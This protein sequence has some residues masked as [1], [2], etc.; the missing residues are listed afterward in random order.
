MATNITS[1]SSDDRESRSSARTRIGFLRTRW[2]AIGAAVAVSLGAG[3]IGLVHATVDSGD[4]P[5]LVD[6]NP[7]RLTDTRADTQVGPRSTPLGAGEQ[8]DVV[9]HGANGNCNIP[10]EA[11]ALSLNVTALNATAPT[12]VT[13]FPTDEAQPTTSNLN[14]LPG[15]APTPNAVTTGLDGA[16]TFSLFNAF[17]TTDV[18]VDVNGYYEHHNHDDRYVQQ[19][20]MLWAVV[21]ADGT[22]ER[23]SDGVT[24]AE[25]L[26]L[27]PTGDYAVVFDRDIS[28]CAYQ[29]TV[30]RPGV[31]VNPSPGFAQVA[32]WTDDPDN[33]VIV[34][35][36]DQ[37]G[38]GVEN[39]GFHLLVTC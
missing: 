13:V 37:N 7:C 3:G 24:S 32:N 17:G 36:K 22:L 5:V 39:R 33:G 18:I 20:D 29:A 35:T 23:S 26:N 28:D 34:F 9:A 15:Q 21:D 38:A 14:L 10:S 1:T 16:G 11:I 27:L 8:Y 25:L 30:G 4:R 6:I 12:F 31:N 19:A 2:A